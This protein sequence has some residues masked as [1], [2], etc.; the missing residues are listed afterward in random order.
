MV[1]LRLL[2][3]SSLSTWMMMVFL[4]L[5]CSLQV[6][7]ELL[8]H[9]SP[10]NLVISPLLHYQILQALKLQRVAAFVTQPDLQSV[11]LLAYAQLP[12]DFKLSLAVSAPGSKTL[13]VSL[14]FS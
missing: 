11:G 8:D 2:L 9:S 5:L 4:L 7:G 3:H 1:V 12:A 10:T 14:D 13:R 6:A